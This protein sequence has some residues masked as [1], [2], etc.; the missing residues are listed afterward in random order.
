MAGNTVRSIGVG[1]ALRRAREIRGISLD[2][3]ARDTRLPSERLRALEAED[4]EA[5]QGEVFVRASLRTYAQY[6]GLSAE[7]VV[8][9]YAKHVD[10]PEP[11]PPPPQVGRVERALA[12]ARIRDSQK[13]FL[14]LAGV[15]MGALIAVGLVSRGGAPQAADLS[16]GSSA[17]VP[18]PASPI[19]AVVS[20]RAPVQLTVTVDGV[21]KVETLGE[22]ET[23]SFAAEDE[24]A[25]AV[26]DAAAIEV[27]VAGRRIELPDAPGQAW[28]GTFTQG[29]V[30]ASAVPSDRRSS[31]SAIVSGSGAP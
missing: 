11:P 2:A 21:E 12:A 5:L 8:R 27:T 22:G 17:I 29:W 16:T 15:V 9:A 4:F 25:L 7:K 24:L 13:F 3:A 18:S 1:Q 14:V 23:L 30:S 10:D 19:D 20:A 31:G 26:E 6:L 28:S